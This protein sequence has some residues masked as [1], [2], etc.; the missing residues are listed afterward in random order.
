MTRLF[1]DDGTDT[2]LGGD[3]DDSLT[4]GPGADI[5]NGEAGNDTIH[6]TIVGEDT[7]DGGIG[8]DMVNF[9]AAVGAIVADLANAAHKLTAV[10]WVTGGNFADT[11]TGNAGD[12]QLSGGGGGDS[13][14]GGGGADRL[15]G[16][17]GDDLLVGGSGADALVGGLG[18]DTVS[19]GT[20]LADASPVSSAAVG[21]SYV[22]SVEIVAARVIS[23]NGVRVDL[24]ANMS[25]SAGALAGAVAAQGSD[26]AGDWFHGVEHLV[27]SAFNDRLA[28]TN[29]SSTVLGGDG[30]DLIYGGAGNDTLRGEGGDD[31]IYG[32][33]GIDTVDGGSGNDRLFGGG[34]QD[35]LIGGA[36]NDLLDAGDAGDVLIGGADNDTLIGGNGADTYQLGRAT[37]SDTIYN[38]DDDSARDA[39]DFVD[40]ITYREIWFRKSGK[41]L[42]VNVLGGTGQAT[43]KDW[44]VNATAGDWT[45]A[46]NFYVDVIIAGTHYNDTL[47]NLSGLLA[48]M[49]Q[50]GAPPA[51]FDALSA[52]HQAAIE[53]AWGQNQAPT[54]VAAGRKS[55]I[56][57]RG[58]DDH[59]LSRFQLH[60]R[61]RCH[62]AREPRGYRHHHGRRVPVGGCSRPIFSAAA[63]PGP[64]ACV[65]RNMRAARRPSSSPCRRRAARFRP[66]SPSRTSSTARWAAA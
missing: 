48:V 26:A 23:L 13:L 8:T 64:S 31:V 30:D 53:M 40:S 65:R 15:D 21:S 35:T 50:Y 4:G 1:G 10:E 17:D 37:G 41:D 56:D 59:R 36:G 33:A 52:A 5:V 18:V 16:G 54:I 14:W 19:Y 25:T 6:A 58:A 3:G 51:S 7:I 32:E 2:L 9:Q 44:F 22:N 63:R 45:A 47:V 42:I 55:G 27:G 66:R 29:N 57:Q 43:V 28:G 20:A 12:N 11:I 39:I 61:R 38:Y 49:S 60:H 24:I 34:E 46:D 62:P